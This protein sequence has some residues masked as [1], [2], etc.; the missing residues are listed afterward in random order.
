V[1]HGTFHLVAFLVTSAFF[2]LSHTDHWVQGVICGMAYQWLV[3]RKGR[4]GDAMLAHAV[5]NLII[6]GY[7]I[8][9]GRWEFS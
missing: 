2:G 1:A 7:V 6:S 3:L 8:V 5:T 9:T 4:L